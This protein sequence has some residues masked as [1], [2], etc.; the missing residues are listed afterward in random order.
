MA[1]LG[2]TYTNKTQHGK[3]LTSWSISSATKLLIEQ[4]EEAKV[5]L[6]RD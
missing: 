1:S 3:H 4:K 5:I 6:Q 2:I